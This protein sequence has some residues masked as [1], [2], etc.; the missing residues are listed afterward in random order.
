MQQDVADGTR[1]L[2]DQGI[3]DPTRTCIAGWSYGGYVAFTASFM[4]TDVFRCSV[5][6]AGVSDLRAMLR[7]VRTGSRS[8]DVNGGGGGGQQSMSYQYWTD[9]IGD[10]SRDDET[11][12]QYSA[13]QNAHRVSIP[14]LII[15]GDED[16]TVPIQQSILMQEAMERAGKP[17]RLIVL[18][19]A[20][21][22][23]TPLQGNAMR[24]VLS[25]SLAF[26]NQHI[27]PGVPPGSQ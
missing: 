10:P 16:T 3:A 11:L 18:E 14:L 13:A 9:A 24:T 17:T 2:I 6:G 21:H 19:D 23:V 27:G 4:N 25:E 5:A 7:W 12:D 20:D 1:Y 8:N 26:F 22:Y 15:H